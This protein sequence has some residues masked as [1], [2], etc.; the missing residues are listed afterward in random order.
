MGFI[1]PVATDASG[2][3]KATGS[4][5]TLG[6]N[7]FLNLLVTKLQ[8]QDPL[9]PSKDE[10]FV[11]QLAQFSTLEQ[12][13]NISEGISTS[14]QWDFLQM[15]SLNNVMASGLIG[16][17]VR[18]EYSGV[19]FDGENPAKIS[20]TLPDDAKSMTF[21]IRDSGGNVVARLSE[22]D[23]T[24]GVNTVTW[25]GKAT[26][27]N[28]VPEGYY[29]IEASA[30]DHSDQPIAA[31]LSVIGTVTGVVYRDGAAYIKLGDIEIP[32]GDIRSVAEKGSL[33]AK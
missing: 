2:K 9:N 33:T 27:G 11:A 8:N 14:N 19:A 16:K 23:L 22:E 18:A 7:D 13:S 31:K 3:P 32:L 12:M 1:S 29:T 21:V 15:Q 17:D 4:L 20:F 10:E 25:D 6:K 30:L 24:K 26:N 5:Q 28:R